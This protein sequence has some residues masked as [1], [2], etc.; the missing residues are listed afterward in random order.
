MRRLVLSV[1]AAALAA[2]LAAAPAVLAEVRAALARGDGIAAEADLRRL[3][4]AGTP[5]SA[6]AADMGEALLQQGEAAR[7]RD[8]LSPG[9]FA[10]GQEARGWRLLAL[11]ERREGNLPAAATAVERG[12]AL[13]PGDSLLWLELGRVR[14][15]GGNQLQALEAARRALASGA[16]QPRVLEFTA[17]LLGDSS[18]DAAALAVYQQALARAPDDLALLGG[19]GAALLELGRAREMLGIAR[20]MLALDRGNATAFQLQAVLAAR[21][22]QTM[23]ARAMLERLPPANPAPAAS[24][25][26]RAVLELESGNAHLAATLL[27]R[28]ADRQPGNERVADLLARALYE[29]G[30]SQ[31]LFARF[32]AAAARPDARPYLLLLLARAHEERGDRAAAAPLL[33]RAALAEAVPLQPA[34][35]PD[36]PQV[37]A[38][39]WRDHPFAPGLSQAY[40]R[41]LIAA[42]DLAG[43]QAV[44]ARLLA[45]QPG[46]AVVQG[47]A[48]DV[49][50]LAGK[51]AAALRHYQ[52][53]AQV[54]LTGQLALR[55]TA[56]LERD[57]RTAAVGSWLADYRARFPGDRRLAQL[58]AQ[59]AIAVGDWATAQGLL[60]GVRRR[61]GGRDVQL[62]ADLAQVQVRLGQAD[63]AIATARR[64]AQLAPA[65]PAVAEA[66]AAAL[67]ASGAH[68][69]AAGQ[70]RALS[71]RSKIR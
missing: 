51:P 16:D 2:P 46:S 11:L 37:F 49:A 8:W 25:L 71:T 48:G 65:S 63:A 31:Q 60:D 54:R 15:Q 29:A 21:A 26:L 6:L 34:A 23:L 12:L 58:A 43:A 44:T 30:D 5:R 70:W 69:R 14:Y 68:P 56:A 41:S 9:R 33:D 13:V 28:L 57:G 66:L 3:L 39:R 47:L 36:A 19:T 17:Q 7:A 42:G 61:G 24:D 50:L 20:R 27:A 18:G 55:I 64:A 1:V 10:P 53:A 35:A 59:R 67:A 22:G 4:E 38:A 40:L 45:L 32:A 62:L 52:A